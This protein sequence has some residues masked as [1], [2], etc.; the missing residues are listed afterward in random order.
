MRKLFYTLTL[1]LCVSAMASSNECL[2]KAHHDNTRKEAAA[3][4]VEKTTSAD[5]DNAEEYS[6]F[7]LIKY[8][9]I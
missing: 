8:L 4:P 1:I 7:Q 9:Y 3:K 6:N 2:C 5:K